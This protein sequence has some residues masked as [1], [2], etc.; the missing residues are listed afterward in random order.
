MLVGVRRLGPADWKKLRVLRLRALRDSPEAFLGD[1]ER[2]ETYSGNYWQSKCTQEY[3]F[4]AEVGEIATGFA[5]LARAVNKA[6]PMHIESMWV[7]P[8]CRGTGVGRA[9]VQRL[10]AEVKYLGESEIRLWVFEEN[11]DGRSFFQR[12]GYQG[13]TKAQKLDLGPRIVVEQE[14]RKELK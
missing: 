6:E 11:A 12:L 1:V 2:E 9:I 3:W 4:V 14:F 13:P 8:E 10:E 7:D 5:N